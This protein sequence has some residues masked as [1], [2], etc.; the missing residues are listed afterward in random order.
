MEKEREEEERERERERER[1]NSSATTSKPDTTR[2]HVGDGPYINAAVTLIKSTLHLRQTCVSPD[3]GTIQ[4]LRFFP[5]PVSEQ[6]GQKPHNCHPTILNY[7]R[8]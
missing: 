4:A 1:E 7:S 8:T 3:Q 2:T 6:H 5:I